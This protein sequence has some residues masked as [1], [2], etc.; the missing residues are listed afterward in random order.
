MTVLVV[1]SSLVI[2]LGS[3][4]SLVIARVVVPL[5]VTALVA[6][7][8]SLEI[9]LVADQSF[10]TVLAVGPSLVALIAGS[11]KWYIAQLDLLMSIVS[12]MTALVVD[13]SL[14]IASVLASSIA[15]NH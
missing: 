14:M 12:L 3:A 5:L 11:H 7:D 8:P 10:V 4:P 1:G 15:P 6:V 2:A 13:L 9:A